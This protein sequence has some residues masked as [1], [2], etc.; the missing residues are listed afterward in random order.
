[1]A[2]SHSRLHSG[3]EL[4]NISDKEVPQRGRH[5]LDVCTYS[6]ELHASRLL[7]GNVWCQ[8]ARNNP[9]RNSH[10]V[11][12][13]A[14]CTLSLHQARLS[15]CQFWLQIFHNN[16]YWK[17][18]WI[19]QLSC[20]GFIFPYWHAIKQNYFWRIACLSQ[21]FGISDCS[22]QWSKQHQQ[23]NKSWQQSPLRHK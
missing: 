2:Q 18:S 17:S 21:G 15:N 8:N 11:Q 23:N 4:F 16:F 9:C 5:V 13:S 6:R 22:M 20:P 12:L 10:T 19:A 14:G 3:D 1:M 7:C